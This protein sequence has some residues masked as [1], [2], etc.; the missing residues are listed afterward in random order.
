MR[1]AVLRRRFFGT[2][3]DYEPELAGPPDRDP[4]EAAFE[5]AGVDPAGRGRRECA[6]ATSTSTMRW[7]RHSPGGRRS[8]AAGRARRR[9]RRSSGAAS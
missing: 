8:T 1:D 2:V 5:L 6:S 4:L 7:I 3:P 9:Q